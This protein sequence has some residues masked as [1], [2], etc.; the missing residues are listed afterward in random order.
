MKT[1]RA[2]I[3]FYRE[4]MEHFQE[5]S[6]TKSAQLAALLEE[7]KAL[8]EELRSMAQFHREDIERLRQSHAEDMESLRT[9]LEKQ[10]GHMAEVNAGLSEQVRDAMASSKAVRSRMYG[11]STEQR[12]LLNKR[13]EV[14]RRD[15]EDD[16]DGTPPSDTPQGGQAQQGDVSAEACVTT[17][18]GK[19]KRG[20]RLTPDQAEGPMS[21]DT[22][23]DH[24]LE[25]FMQLPEGARLMPGTMEFRL[26]KHIPARTECH[27][28]HYGRYIL[29]RDDDKDI[30]SD[31]LPASIRAQRPVEGCL[32]SPE[33]LAFIM[34]QKYAY[35]QPQRRIRMMLKDMGVHIPKKT[36]NRYVLSGADT[37]LEM[38][39]CTY[40]E[41]CRHGSY[42]MIDETV[43][44]V[45]VDDRQL[46]RRYL[47]RYMWEFYNRSS[48]LVEYVYDD[49]SRGRKVLL[50]FFGDG[51][52]LLNTL[53]SCDGYN[54]YR[55]FDSDEF[56]GVTVVGCWTHARRNFVDALESC[57]PQCEEVIDMIDRMFGVEAECRKAGLDND[58]RLG[59]RKKRTAPVLK[60]LRTTLERM[61]NDTGLMAVSLMRKAVGYVRNQWDHLSNIMKTGVAEISNNLSEQRIRPLKLSLKNCLNIGSEKAAPLHAFM[62]SLA[63]SCRLNS[64]NIQ[65]Y[66]SCLFSKARSQLAP[67]DLRGL[68]PNHYT[69]Q[70]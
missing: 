23:V 64:V 28:Y 21:F 2:D 49:G 44:T 45:G 56:P 48:N 30:F 65:E 42:F 58:Q 7:N 3:E 37:L 39:G 12:D 16:S 13:R 25:E 5:E 22:I 32:L 20:R 60:S 46:G 47:N 19:R 14:S 11:R 15:E 17:G 24:P 33:I 9:S 63:E 57:R 55:L 27:V 36:F 38:L 50:N 6:A 26:L 66:F 35:H 62:H 29:E 31:T 54:A 61:W 10:L 53:I 34:T 4:M 18:E 8:R 51:A 1:K 52:P 41:E 67:D 68:L 40:R 69:T 59:Q 70:C 43:M